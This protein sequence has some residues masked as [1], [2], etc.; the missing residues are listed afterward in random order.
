[1]TQASSVYTDLSV[2]ENVAYWARI[3]GAERGEAESVIEHL[4]LASLAGQPA[5]RSRQEEDRGMLCLDKSL[6]FALRPG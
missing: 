4:H 5:G 3:S 2:R 6:T 1:M